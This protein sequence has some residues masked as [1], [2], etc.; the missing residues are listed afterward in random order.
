[1][2][3][4]HAGCEVAVV[5][6]KRVYD[7]PRCTKCCQV[8]LFVGRKHKLDQ[9][10]EKRIFRKKPKRIS[11]SRGTDC[12]VTTHGQHQSFRQHISQRVLGKGKMRKGEVRCAVWRTFPERGSNKKRPKI[13][14][15]GFLLRHTAHGVLQGP[16][17][18]KLSQSH[19]QHAPAGRSNGSVKCF[20]GCGFGSIVM[21]IMRSTCRH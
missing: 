15:H 17:Q 16:F 12:S 9:G 8:N 13:T 20:D 19:S 6:K 2:G 7:L 21:L 4:A 5:E 1:M 10:L 11:N 3:G 18:V 14:Q